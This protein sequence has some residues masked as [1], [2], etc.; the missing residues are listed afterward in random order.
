MLHHHQFTHS[1]HSINAIGLAYAC[2]Q[3]CSLAG[4]ECDGHRCVRLVLHRRGRC[5][6]ADQCH[7]WFGTWRLLMTVCHFYR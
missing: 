6:Q 7:L 1:S 2:G 3:Q 4:N 5:L